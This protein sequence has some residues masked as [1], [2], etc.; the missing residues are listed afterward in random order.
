MEIDI[1]NFKEESTPILCRLSHIHTVHLLP[2]ALWNRA[3]RRIHYLQC[4]PR[5]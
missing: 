4:P 2:S 3:D 5:I 1:T